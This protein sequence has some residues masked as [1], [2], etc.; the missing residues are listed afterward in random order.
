LQ[1][2]ILASL[3]HPFEASSHRRMYAVTIPLRV[4]P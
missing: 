2:D 3:L 1:S 4:T